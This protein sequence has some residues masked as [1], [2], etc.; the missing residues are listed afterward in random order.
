MKPI[1][2]GIAVVMVLS[3]AV[4]EAQ[5][6]FDL[7]RAWFRPMLVSGTDEAC[8]D[9]LAHGNRLVTEAKRP[10]LRWSHEDTPLGAPGFE[11]IDFYRDL[12]VNGPTA[13]QRYVETQ[14]TKLYLVS[15]W[16]PEC[17]G[18]CG[19]PPQLFASPAPFPPAGDQR[20]ELL[21]TLPATP[22]IADPKLVRRGDRYYAAAFYENALFLTR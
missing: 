20:E 8:A 3:A 16:Y 7:E 21:R 19:R 6:S 18:D 10:I 17:H 13:D 5:D 12:P 9:L 4:V 11:P 22:A 15:A 2:I 1:S 14:G